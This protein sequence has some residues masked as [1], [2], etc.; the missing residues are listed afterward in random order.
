[1]QVVGF[2]SRQ[3]QELNG[4]LALTRSRSATAS[5][6]ASVSAFEWGSLEYSASLTA[7]RS[8]LEGAP[9]PPLALLQDHHAALSV[10]PVG[11]HQLSLAADYYASRGPAVP[12]R[13]V[14]ADLSYRYVLPT[15]RKIDLEVRWSNI[16]NTRQYQH[17]YVSQFVLAQITYQLRPAQVLAAVRLSL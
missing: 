2:A 6:K 9:P 3:P 15:A 7:L 10:F 16:F 11:R 17:G 13:A 5:A 1:M 4:R 8:R 12:V 14:F